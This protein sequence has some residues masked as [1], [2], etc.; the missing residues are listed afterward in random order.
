M[1]QNSQVPSLLVRHQVRCY[2]HHTLRVL[3]FGCLRPLIIFILLSLKKQIF[4]RPVS[5]TKKIVLA[6]K[7]NLRSSRFYYKKK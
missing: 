6:K 7:T 2:T 5:I 3:P 4:A 1:I